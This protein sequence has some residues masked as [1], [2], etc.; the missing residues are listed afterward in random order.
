M[1]IWHELGEEATDLR[2]AF[3]L[4]QAHALWVCFAIFGVWS[5]KAATHRWS[6]IRSF[7]TWQLRRG[8]C[9]G[10]W[11]PDQCLN[12]WR[13]PRPCL[14]HRPSSSGATSASLSGGFGFPC[15]AAQPSAKAMPR[16][17]TSVTRPCPAA[18]TRR[19]R[20]TK[21]RKLVD[22]FPMMPTPSNSLYRSV[23]TDFTASLSETMWGNWARHGTRLYLAETGMCGIW[24]RNSRRMWWR[25]CDCAYFPEDDVIRLVPELTD[26]P[27]E[28]DNMIVKVATPDMAL[29]PLYVPPAVPT[30]PAPQPPVDTCLTHGPS[31]RARTFQRNFVV[32]NDVV[33]GIYGTK[34]N[35][36]WNFFANG[37][38]RLE[39]LHNNYFGKDISTMRLPAFWSDCMTVEQFHTGFCG[40]TPKEISLDGW[41]NCHDLP[42]DQPLFFSVSRSRLWS[43]HQLGPAGMHVFTHYVIMGTQAFVGWGLITT[44]TF[45]SGMISTAV[46]V[47]LSPFC[48]PHSISPPVFFS[49]TWKKTEQGWKTSATPRICQPYPWCSQSATR[50]WGTAH[51]ASRLWSCYVAVPHTFDLVD[52]ISRRVVMAS[53]LAS[54]C[55]PRCLQEC[56]PLEEAAVCGGTINVQHGACSKLG[57]AT[58]LPSGQSISS[59]R[60]APSSRSYVVNSGRRW[61]WARGFTSHACHAAAVWCAIATSISV[62]HTRC[63][64]W[65]WRWHGGCTI[66]ALVVLWFN[67]SVA[68]WM[69]RKRTRLWWTSPGFGKCLQH[70]ATRLQQRIGSSRPLAMTIPAWAS[71]KQQGEAALWSCNRKDNGTGPESSSFSSTPTEEEVKY[72]LHETIASSL[73][74]IEAFLAEE[75]NEPEQ[76]P[77]KRCP[78]DVAAHAFARKWLHLRP[79]SYF[80]ARL[81]LPVNKHSARSM[82]RSISRLV[83]ERKADEDAW[84]DYWESRLC[85]HA[86]FCLAWLVREAA[87]TV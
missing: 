80:L 69:T 31:L 6:W 55:S 26:Y 70:D 1:A 12:G 9:S 67:T 37:L 10:L 36:L 40:L 75:R 25:T 32:Q 66:Q 34:P 83:E 78:H 7:S 74:N 20:R 19:E 84:D 81:N 30:V 53:D 28:P 87:S 72:P 5:K 62:C 2:L 27:F 13:Y 47:F 18:C 49:L 4:Q 64:V 8:R 21:V 29:N 73:E 56:W 82:K 51:S 44:R 14:V 60:P 65:E 76:A 61:D 58:P 63:R 35:E 68:T 17:S 23:S 48:Q 39:P 50:Q 16:T 52:S 42:W 11:C 33:F 85:R 86:Q 15:S 22:V 77:G 45:S 57:I 46:G 24:L 54:R 41:Q 79:T 71:K 59:G 43:Y 38:T 3:L